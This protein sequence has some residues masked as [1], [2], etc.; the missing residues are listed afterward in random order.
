MYLVHRIMCSI[1]FMLAANRAQ[2]YWQVN[3]SN[4]VGTPTITITQVT[5]TNLPGFVYDVYI[6]ATISSSASFGTVSLA[7]TNYGN[8]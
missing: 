6:N 3:H 8:L 5:G 7:A 2:A 1:V 4:L